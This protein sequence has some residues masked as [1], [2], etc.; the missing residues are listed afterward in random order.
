M[1]F[2]PDFKL[3][4]IFLGVFFFICSQA[5]LR[6]TVCFLSITVGINECILQELLFLFEVPE[7]DV[8]N[9]LF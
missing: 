7:G 3:L 8:L 6:M 1:F 4:V 9:L 5:Q 2:S